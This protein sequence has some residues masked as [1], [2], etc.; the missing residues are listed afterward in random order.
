MSGPTMP[1]P[2]SIRN[3]VPP[4]TNPNTANAP[5][6]SGAA[7]NQPVNTT[8]PSTPTMPYGR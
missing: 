1:N 3:T 5:L 6:G 4:V 7:I 2:I 8:I